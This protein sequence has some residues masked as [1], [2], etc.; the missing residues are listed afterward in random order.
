MGYETSRSCSTSREWEWRGQQSSGLGMLAEKCWFVYVGIYV[1]AV[2]INQSTCLGCNAL[3]YILNI[4]SVQ[5]CL[6]LQMSV[7]QKGREEEITKFS[8]ELY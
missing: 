1:P 5:F 6:K 4:I 7:M 3:N 2:F 8:Y